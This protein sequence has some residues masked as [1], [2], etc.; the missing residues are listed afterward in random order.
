MVLLRE[1]PR[2]G[3]YVCSAEREVI[4]GDRFC[5]KTHKNFKDFNH[6]VQIGRIHEI[7]GNRGFVEDIQL[8]S[9]VVEIAVV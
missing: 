1:R 3:C 8:S 7:Y 5:L 9:G 2:L 4:R 6:F